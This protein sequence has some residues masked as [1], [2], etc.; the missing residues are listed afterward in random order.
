MIYLQTLLLVSL[1]TS[2]SSAMATVVDAVAAAPRRCI[3]LLFILLLLGVS[4]AEVY[5]PHLGTKR[6]VFQTKYGDIE[7]GF[8][9]KVAPKTVDHIFKLVR[10]GAYNTNHFFRVIFQPPISP[11]AGNSSVVVA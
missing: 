7:F 5:D 8:Y 10:L 6:V 9:P 4:V 3:L 11:I 2:F 1:I